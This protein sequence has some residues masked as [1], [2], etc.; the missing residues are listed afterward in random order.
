MEHTRLPKCVMIG[1]MLGSAGCVGGKN[2]TGWGVPWT[3]SDLSASTLTSGQ[4]QSRTRENAARFMA[5]W[6]AAEDARAGLR[7]A[8]VYPNVTGRTKESIAL[9]KRAHAGL[10]VIVD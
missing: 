3:T 6:I 4:L 9:S 5:K 7:H 1:E 10:L 8:V 2:N